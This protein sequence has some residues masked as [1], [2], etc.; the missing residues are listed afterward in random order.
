MP[1]CPAE[2]APGYRPRSASNA[3]KEIVEAETR[4]KRERRRGRRDRAPARGWSVPRPGPGGSRVARDRRALE[5][6]LRLWDERFAKE[7]GPL[8][9]RVKKLFEAFTRC[10]DLSFGFLRLRCLNP[11]CQ[12]KGELLLGFS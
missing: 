12:K 11:K 3:L 1:A 9:P 8:H 2:G 6:L 5:D 4:P 10:G 7:F